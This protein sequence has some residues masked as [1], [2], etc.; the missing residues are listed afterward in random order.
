MITV[1]IN[2]SQYNMINEI[3]KQSPQKIN[4]AVSL[5]INRSL[6]M[7]RTEQIRRAMEK[8]SVKKKDLLE[9]L[10]LSKANSGNLLGKILSKGETIGLDHFKLNQKTRKNGKEVKVDVKK[11]GMK[12]LANA[13][14]AYNDGRLGA[15]VRT[16]DARL[17]IKRLKG[18][19][20]PQM[21]GEMTIIEY[22]QGFVEDKFNMRL[23]HELERLLK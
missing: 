19:S 20:A 1:K 23:E 17:P 4:N 14:I 2:E 7:T 3:I 21:L 6:E 22:L 16:S 5:S 18:P 12:S 13:F 10:S 15:F 8:Y 11:S 9:G